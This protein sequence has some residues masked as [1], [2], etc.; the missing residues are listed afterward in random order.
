MGTHSDRAVLRG[1]GTEL[2]LNRGRRYH[3]RGQA[4]FET[5]AMMPLF[6][7]GLFGIFFAVRAS[8]LS[9]RTQI[10][11][12]YGGLVHALDNP[13]LSYSIYSVYSTIDGTP[14]VDPNADCAAAQISELT[15]SRARF[16]QPVGAPLTFCSGAV[17]GVPVPSS[18][19]SVLLENDFIG[20]E[21]SAQIQG[22][23]LQAAF[24]GQTSATTSASQNFFR[25]PDVGRL[26]SCTSLGSPIKRSLEGANDTQTLTAPPTAMPL[27]IPATPLLQTP[28]SCA[29]FGP[30]LPAPGQ[31]DDPKPPPPTPTPSPPPPTPTPSPPPPTRKPSPPP[32]T[33]VPTP[34][35]KP[36]VAPPTPHPTPP[37][38]TPPPPPPT[39]PPCDNGNGKNGN[40]DNGKQCR[41]TPTPPPTPSPTPTPNLNGTPPPG[42]VG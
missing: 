30:V 24:R 18:N 5:A 6:L 31:T 19:G 36:T 38:P 3:S 26:M 42:S 29:T 27:Q 1:A 21:A 7:L 35:P 34:T 11:V 33:P 8:A 15:A 32:P 23:F 22:S 40:G 28:L 39:L 12:R 2:M 25:S 20:L 9:E 16:W 37:P 4:L 10:G 17:T 13:Y 41:A 14:P